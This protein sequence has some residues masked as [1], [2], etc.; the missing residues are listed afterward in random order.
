MKLWAASVFF[1]VCRL[2]LQ[3]LIGGHDSS[4]RGSSWIRETRSLCPEWPGPA[5]PSTPVIGI[6]AWD[7]LRAHCVHV[8][9]LAR[10]CSFRD[11]W[12]ECWIPI[13]PIMIRRLDVLVCFVIL[14]FYSC[15]LPLTVIPFL[16]FPCRIIIMTSDRRS[17]DLNPYSHVEFC[18][19]GRCPPYIPR[20]ELQAA[21]HGLRNCWVALN[22]V[23]TGKPSNAVLGWPADR[24]P[25]FL[26]SSSEPWAMNLHHHVANEH[27]FLHVKFLAGW[28]PWFEN[29]S[30]C[31]KIILL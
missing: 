26:C 19:G 28:L 14:L 24:W 3:N 13:I 10:S 12:F 30:I 21:A 18:F 25:C 1:L 22:Y 6:F 7:Y 17:R 9:C 23:G 29:C 27:S 2:V 5:F 15:I 31:G 16:I 11:L 4:P 8:T 20:Y